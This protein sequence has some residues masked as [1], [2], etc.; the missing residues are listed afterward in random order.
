MSDQIRAG[1]CGGSEE[2]DFTQTSKLKR[3]S[4]DNTQSFIGDCVGERV[5][6]YVEV[7][8]IEIS[9]SKLAIEG[10]KSGATQDDTS[11]TERA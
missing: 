7:G 3:D 4:E 10:V 8:S 1:I 2:A 11:E 5:G 6:L 9:N